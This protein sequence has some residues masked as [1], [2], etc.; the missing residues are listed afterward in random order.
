MAIHEISRHSQHA[1]NNQSF[2]LPSASSFMDMTIPSLNPLQLLRI[3]LN[4]VAK[5]R[6]T[7]LLS[8]SSMPLAIFAGLAA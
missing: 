3:A 4:L 8:P 2:L 6:F 1:S 7:T 5:S